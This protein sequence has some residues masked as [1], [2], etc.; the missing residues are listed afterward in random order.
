MDAPV[1]RQCGKKLRPTKRSVERRIESTNVMGMRELRVLVDR[2]VVPGSFD[3]DNA[4]C[5]LRCGYRYGL[6]CVRQH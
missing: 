5:T 2:V 3:L 1:C 6:R 4:F